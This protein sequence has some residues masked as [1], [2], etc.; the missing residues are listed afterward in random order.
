LAGSSAYADQNQQ[1]SEGIHELLSNLNASI[2]DTRNYKESISEL[3]K[4]LAALNKV[5]GNML[6]AMNPG[7]NA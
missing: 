7:G 3:S 5:Y 2:E 1:L 6:T 4:N